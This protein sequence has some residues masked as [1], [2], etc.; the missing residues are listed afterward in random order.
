MRRLLGM[1]PSDDDEL[2][3]APQPSLTRIDDL[4]GR[5]TS[6][7]LP[8]EVTIEGEPVELPPGIDVSA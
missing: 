4:A 3:L 8:V 5:L 7:G 1:L 2:G 6:T